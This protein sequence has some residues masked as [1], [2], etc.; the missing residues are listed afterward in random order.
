M[1]PIVDPPDTGNPVFDFLANVAVVSLLICSIFISFVLIPIRKHLIAIREQ[2]E[3]S[4]NDSPYPNL[5]DNIDANQAEVIKTLNL[6]KENQEK[7]NQ[8][9]QN[10]RKEALQDREAISQVSK[11]LDEHISEKKDFLPRLTALE[12]NQ[13]RGKR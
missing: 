8:E 13:K 7:H 6:I 3:N 4:H 9:L 5:R 12:N 1:P 10:L 2:T 11:R